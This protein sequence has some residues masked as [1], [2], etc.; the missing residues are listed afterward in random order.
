MNNKIPNQY[1]GN[2]LI[3]L[4]DTYLFAGAPALKLQI[5][6]DIINYTKFRLHVANTALKIH[7]VEF[8]KYSTFLNKVS[9]VF[10]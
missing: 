9:Q 3:L 4:K 2:C 7:P 1:N 6:I 5:F 10:D 8:T